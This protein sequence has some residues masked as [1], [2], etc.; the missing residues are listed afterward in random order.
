M[1]D[2]VESRIWHTRAELEKTFDEIQDRINVPKQV[3]KLTAKVKNSCTSHPLP[4]I[5]GAAAGA[6]V[7]IGTTIALAFRAGD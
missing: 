7:I 5:V 6:V 2:A 4:W 3:G 1:S